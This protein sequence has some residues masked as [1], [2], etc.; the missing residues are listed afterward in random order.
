MMMVMMIIMMI[1]KELA[2]S[3]YE[4]LS[5]FL[6]YNEMH[7]ETYE[8]HT[9]AHCSNR[10][11]EEQLYYS[12][13]PCIRRSFHSPHKRMSSTVR[14]WGNSAQREQGGLW[15]Q[16]ALRE[17]L[18]LPSW[19]WASDFT[20]ETA[21]LGVNWAWKHQALGSSEELERKRKTCIPHTN[22]TKCPAPTFPEIKARLLLAAS[23]WPQD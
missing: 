19:T 23:D 20:S 18:V 2:S 3:I 21:F 9:L 12:V 7:G 10:I 13:I 14:K 15:R 22:S 6:H 5:C 4:I 17:A 1:I 8:M 16:T 11:E